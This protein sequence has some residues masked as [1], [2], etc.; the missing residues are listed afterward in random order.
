MSCRLDANALSAFIG[1]LVRSALVKRFPKAFPLAILSDQHDHRFPY[2]GDHGILFAA[3]VEV[4]KVAEKQ[5]IESSFGICAHLNISISAEEID[6]A[7]REMWGQFP[8]ENF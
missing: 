7:R 6:E 4:E 3:P 2:P 8:R 5:P 1:D